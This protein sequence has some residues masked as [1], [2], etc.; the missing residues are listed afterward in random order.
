MNDLVLFGTDHQSMYLIYTI[1]LRDTINGAH[2]SQFQLVY[3]C[4]TTHP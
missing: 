3:I 2:V 1:L 4:N